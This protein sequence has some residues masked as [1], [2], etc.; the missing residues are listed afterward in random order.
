MKRMLL[1]LVVGVLFCASARAQTTQP[2]EKSEQGWLKTVSDV[3]KALVGGDLTATE[4]AMASRSAVRR[5]DGAG[6]DEL[7]RLAERAAG[8][9]DAK[10]K[11]IG[12]HAYV[13]P[14]LAMAADIA[15]DFKTAIA[16]PDRVKE[17]FIVDDPDQMKRANSTA[18]QW[19]SEQIGAQ[20][21]VPVGVIVL[22]CPSPAAPESTE[23]NVPTYEV[24]FVL[25]KGE[26]AAPR[27]F[28]VNSVVYGWPVG[29]D[30]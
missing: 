5:F 17:K 9:L 14:P 2:T 6:S 1:A 30:R 28:K 3:A 19:V 16:V 15:A 25:M 8:R 20:K 10:S 21:G 22:W 23:K 26:E 18:V 27:E 13:Y 7:W 4:S 29:D 24:M 11:I 12:Y